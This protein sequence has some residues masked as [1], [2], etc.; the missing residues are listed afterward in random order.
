MKYK[1]CS[2]GV[3]SRAGSWLLL[4]SFK[5]EAKGKVSSKDQADETQGQD[6]YATQPL[7]LAQ[8]Q[9]C[10]VIQKRL[11]SQISERFGFETHQQFTYILQDI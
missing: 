1:V 2:G 6:E 3:N 9:P 8:L 11:Y 5:K 7:S 10:N 4:L